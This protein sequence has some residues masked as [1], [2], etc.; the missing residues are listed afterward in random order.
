[1]ENVLFQLG[2]DGNP[3]NLLLSFVMLV[4]FFLFYP[5]LMLSQIMWKLEKTVKDLEEMSEE[6]RKIVAKEIN[7]SPDERLKESLNRFFEFF[8][9]PPVALDTYGIVRKLDHL[10]QNQRERFRYFVKQVAPHM[11][12][13]KQ[14]NIEMG[15]AGGITLYELTKI[16]RHYVEI[17]KKTKSFQIAMILQMQLP[18]IERM[19]K[20][21]FKGTKVLVRGKPIGDAL[22]PY[23]I[24]KLTDNEKVRDVQEE[25]VV[26]RKELYGKDVFLLKAKGPGGRVGRP[27]LAI[28]NLLKEHKFVKIIS[29]DAAAKLEGE[30]TG[31]VAEGVGV[32]MGGPGV[33]RTYIEDVA[34]KNNIPLDSVIVKMSGEEA[35]EPLRKSI[36]DAYPEVVKSIERSLE[37]LKK[38]SKVLI[39]GVGNTS[40]VGNSRKDAE[41]AEKLVEK[42]EHHLKAQKKKKQED[43]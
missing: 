36:I 31:S 27:G 33:E 8:I 24:A 7:S 12:E 4:V 10:I 42:Y 32:A 9:I 11:N 30:K 28:Q 22:G 38:G 39:V 1:M 34:V 21:V 29:I 18:L 35:I 17:T 2:L 16:V 40:G 6:S 13:E 15:L 25:M 19:A 41:E 37:Q 26:A 43:D 20:S 23:V 3:L 14:A 5:R